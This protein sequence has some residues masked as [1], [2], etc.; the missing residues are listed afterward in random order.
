MTN[1]SIEEILAGLLD[2]EVPHVRVEVLAT[3]ILALAPDE[4]ARQVF[5]VL[6]DRPNE[7]V[8]RAVLPLIAELARRED[9]WDRLVE[10]SLRGQGR[11][12]RAI[13]EDLRAA[14]RSVAGQDLPPTRPIPLEDEDIIGNRP[15]RPGPARSVR[16][17]RGELRIPVTT[18]MTNLRYL[19]RLFDALGQAG[20]KVARAKS[21]V[22]D[23]NGVDHL[24]IGGLVVLATWCDRHRIQPRIENAPS[25]TAAYLDRMGLGRW[26]EGAAQIGPYSDPSGWGVAVTSLGTDA[27]ESLAGRLTDLCVKHAWVGARDRTA[28]VILFAELIENVRRHAGGQ[29]IARVGAQYY[30]RKH[31]LNLAIADTGIGVRAS[32]ENGRNDVARARMR[33]GESPLRLAIAP[34]VTSKPV[35]TPDEPGHAGY[36][37]YIASELAVRNGGTFRITSGAS[38]LMR[39]R[40]WNP[41]RQTPYRGTEEESHAPWQGTVVT[42]V[43]DL[44]QLLPISDVYAT[45]PPPRGYADDDFFS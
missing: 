36:G 26:V 24:F 12:P 39:F 1:R 43:L 42:M 21:V 29:T 4:A 20:S 19:S 14:L 44:E 25:S 40:G 13:R 32:F 11:C 10:R 35:T 2:S 18:E 31:R 45:L 34:R 15:G 5:M 23:L 3:E 17:R 27:S 9:R 33:G 6:K 30:P 41:A 37:L 16:D 7:A 28:L 22:M 8:L 38:T